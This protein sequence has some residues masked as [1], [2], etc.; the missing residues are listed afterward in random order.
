LKALVIDDDDGIIQLVSL[1]LRVIWPDIEIVWT[2]LGGEGSEMVK[3]AQPDLVVLDLGLPDISGYD[4]LKTIRSFSKVPLI[5][6]TVRNEEVDV[7]HAFELGADDYIVK[8][9][10]QFEFLA[11]VRSALSRFVPQPA[12]RG[13]ELQLIFGDFRFDSSLRRLEFHNKA[14]DLTSTESVTLRT[15]LEKAGHVVSHKIIAERIWGRPVPD[16]VKIIRVYIRHLREKIEKDPNDPNLL[17]T[18]AGEGYLLTKT[19]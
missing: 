17:I 14:I 16:A 12:A 19:S 1:C 7:V 13:E 2:H 18:K 15:L 3:D 9:F 6:L 10:R 8:P 11:R 5:V 4:V